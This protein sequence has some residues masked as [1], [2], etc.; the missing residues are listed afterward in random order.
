MFVVYILCRSLT[1]EDPELKTS[2]LMNPRWIDITP[3]FFLGA[4]KEDS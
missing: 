3:Y 1:G 2:K 4:R